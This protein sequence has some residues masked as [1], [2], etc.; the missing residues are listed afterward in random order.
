MKNMPDCQADGCQWGQ[1]VWCDRCPLRTEKYL[2]RITEASDPLYRQAAM[3]IQRKKLGLT[4][5]EDYPGVQVAQAVEI[6]DA[7]RNR[8]QAEEMRKEN[9]T[10]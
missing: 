4:R 3:F 6:V 1:A 9:R 8:I 10:S 5:W 7:E 2:A